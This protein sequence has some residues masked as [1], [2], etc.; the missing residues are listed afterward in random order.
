MRFDSASQLRA[1]EILVY[2]A[3]LDTHGFH[4]ITV[5]NVFLVSVFVTLAQ[6]L[7]TF[8]ANFFAAD[9]EPKGA[10]FLPSQLTPFNSHLSSDSFL[11]A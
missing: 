3:L 9:F 6:V 11:L 10:D 7:A 1:L 2:R 5:L 8:Q 4:V